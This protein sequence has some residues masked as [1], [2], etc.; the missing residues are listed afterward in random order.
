M[1]FL[2]GLAMQPVMAAELVSQTLGEWIKLDK[3]DLD[4]IHT[5]PLFVQ[6]LKFMLP[7]LHCC[8]NT[9]VDV[10]FFFLPYG[11]LWQELFG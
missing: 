7:A 9:F 2:T 11:F 1:Y 8:T 4:S 3:N 10:F 6:S 5:D